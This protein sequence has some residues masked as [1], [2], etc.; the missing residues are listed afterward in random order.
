MCSSTSG[1]LLTSSTRHC[2]EQ[3]RSKYLF[4]RWHYRIRALDQGYNERV[5]V[6]GA[7]RYMYDSRRVHDMG[8]EDLCIEVE[9]QNG[10]GDGESDGRLMGE[11][12]PV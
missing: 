4:M 10:P 2:A 5:P 12:H 11:G 1:R 3:L 8:Y 9:G 7:G 6:F